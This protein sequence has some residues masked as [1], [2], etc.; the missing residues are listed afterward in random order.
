LT[1]FLSLS[2]GDFSSPP[3]FSQE[4]SRD[5]EKSSLEFTIKNYQEI[6]M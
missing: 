1:V 3:E 5:D 2:G 4:N 6:F